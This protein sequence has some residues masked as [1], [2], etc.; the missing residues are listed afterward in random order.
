MKSGDKIICF[1]DSITKLYSTELRT[2]LLDMSYNLD[3]SRINAGIGGDTTRHG[4]LRLPQLLDEKPDYTVI[5]F[6]MNDQL[7]NPGKNV[8]I[9]EFRE[10]LKTIAE[11]F[12]QNHSRVILLTIIPV[13]DRE[14]YTR[15]DTYNRAI[16]DVWRELK[17][18][19]VDVNAHWK[20]F[21]RNIPFG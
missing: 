11:K 1:G 20:T 2:R 15:I 13:E 3:V 19:L 21:F 5:S 18:R 6:G 17:V 16:Y 9:E 10:N 7:P 8:P 14:T 4:L 12:I